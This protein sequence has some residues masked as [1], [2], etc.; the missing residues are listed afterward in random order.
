M[1]LRLGVGL[2]LGQN[3]FSS[4]G[5]GDGAYGL[6]GLYGRLGVQLT[7]QLSV[8]GEA[9]ASTL[10]L[11]AYKRLA[12]LVGFTYHDWVCLNAG[13]AMTQ[14]QASTIF[15]TS[16]EAIHTA[17]TARVDFMPWRGK[18]ED[19]TRRAFTFGLAVEAGLTSKDESSPSRGALG[20]YASV[21]YAAY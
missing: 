4:G 20:L 15:G 21:G 3:D 5:I 1:R 6:V 9:A 13:V 10:V 19:G 7:E 18:A 2:H 12:L 11:F 14:N 8:E 17:P 16:T